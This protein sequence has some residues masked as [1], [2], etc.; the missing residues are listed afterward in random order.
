MIFL[1]SS[2]LIRTQV[3]STN[4]SKNSWA[5]L[6]GT[7]QYIPLVYANMIYVASI[8][9]YT[10]IFSAVIRYDMI[11]IIGY[12]LQKNIVDEKSRSTPNT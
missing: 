5:T 12:M 10:S 8:L 6:G 11:D 9:S 1:P 7:Q 2:Y 4:L 3:V